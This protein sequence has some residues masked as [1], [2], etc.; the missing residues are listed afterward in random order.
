MLEQLKNFQAKVQ[1]VA[2]PEEAA[3]CQDIFEDIITELNKKDSEK[4]QLKM[5]INIAHYL[6]QAAASKEFDNYIWGTHVLPMTKVLHDLA[7]FDSTV[8]KDPSALRARHQAQ[9]DLCRSLRSKEKEP[10]EENSKNPFEISII[11]TTYNQ[12]RMTMECIEHIAKNTQNV[13]YEIILIENGSSDGTFEHFCDQP[14][15]KILH[16]VENVGLL[17]A[18]QVFYESHMDE[19]KF[20]MYMNNDVLVTPDWARKMLNCIQS[21]PSIATVMPTTNIVALPFIVPIP[22]LLHD[23]KYFRKFSKEYVKNNNDIWE[24]FVELYA[25]VG[26][27]RPSSRRLF[28]FFEDMFYFKFYYADGDITTLL[29]KSGYRL[30]LCKNVYVHHAQGASWSNKKLANP[31]RQKAKDAAIHKATLRRYKQY[32]IEET[33]FFQKYGYFSSEVIIENKS[34][35]NSI[36]FS[37]PSPLKILF[38]E[39]KRGTEIIYIRNRFHAQKNCNVKIYGVEFDAIFEEDLEKY[40]D[41]SAICESPYDAVKA[42]DGEKFNLIY[43][44][45]QLSHLRDIPSFLNDIYDSLELNGVLLISHHCCANILSLTNIVMASRNSMRDRVRLR[46]ISYMGLNS[47]L[48]FLEDA[49]LSILNIKHDYFVVDSGTD[50]R[51]SKMIY[52][53]RMRERF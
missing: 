8:S 23:Y 3:S 35:L 22:F 45:G 10:I 43:Y 14:G 6:K 38:I 20:W 36:D 40:A 17:P 9:F 30:V 5:A 1:Q 7:V 51:I 29:N 2:S 49:G 18:L 46:K 31:F 11:I 52:N 32:D 42:F 24:D 26:L 12:L 37:N 39:A 16:F 4:R 44:A 41:R 47:I 27:H 53:R 34:V 33:L 48:D 50:L 19:G 25:F 13:K 28:G 21:D 15:I